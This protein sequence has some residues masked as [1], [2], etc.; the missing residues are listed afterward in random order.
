MTNRT[1]I[2]VGRMVVNFILR[3][4]ERLTQLPNGDWLAEYAFREVSGTKDAPMYETK[5]TQ[6][7]VYP[8]K[9]DAAK[10]LYVERSDFSVS[11]GCDYATGVE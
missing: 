6:L 5:W 9:S 2:N 1:Q 11:Y 8:T 10:N 4:D 7:G 3:A